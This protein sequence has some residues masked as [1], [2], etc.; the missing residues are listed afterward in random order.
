[1]TRSAPFARFWHIA[2]LVLPLP[3]AGCN[4]ASTYGTGQAPEMA[5]LHEVSG[6]LLDRN[7]KKTP[8]DYQARAPLVMPPTAS[9]SALPPPAES[10]AAVSPDWPVDREQLTA[11]AD[12]RAEDDDPRNDINQAEYR[13]LKPLTGVL[14][15]SNP[16]EDFVADDEG[17]SDY[18]NTV[19]HAKA[20]R[21]QFAKA[22]ADSK[23]YGRTT[24]RRYLTDPPIAYREPVAADDGTVTAVEP[25]KGNFLTRWWHRR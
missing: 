5:M 3:L 21:D 16:D 4:L 2:L 20:Q 24:E 25:E 13:R 7:K 8:I 6:G 17:K 14:R 18:Y 19:V 1:M 23:G 15:H 22:L 11:E 10:A 9:A 12:A